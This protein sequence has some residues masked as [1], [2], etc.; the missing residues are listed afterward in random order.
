[1]SPVHSSPLI[2]L[3]LTSRPINLSKASANFQLSSSVSTQVEAPERPKY[4]LQRPMR[5]ATQ[6]LCQQRSS[7]STKSPT[8]HPE[9]IKVLT[10]DEKMIL[11]WLSDKYAPSRRPLE[12]LFS[13][14]N[15][16][17]LDA[18]EYFKSL[19]EKLRNKKDIPMRDRVYK[20]LS[21]IIG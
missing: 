2:N 11:S 4:H 10:H 7:Q 9:T 1:M 8:K 18:R 19:H 13:D 5:P 12:D 3:L 6:I 16:N 14:L 21:K 17:L 15:L 20:R